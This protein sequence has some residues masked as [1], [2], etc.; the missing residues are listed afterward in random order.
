MTTVEGMNIPELSAAVVVALTI[1][2]V[3]LQNLIKNWKSTS[4]ES[5]LLKM[6]HEELERMSAQNTALSQELGK[7]Q[8]DLINLSKQLTA[9]TLENQKLHTEVTSLN[10]D[11]SRLHA[12]MLNT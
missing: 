8:I 10:R 6:M 1:I 7:L 11:I 3:G 12:T 4:T 5:S 9:L 2:A